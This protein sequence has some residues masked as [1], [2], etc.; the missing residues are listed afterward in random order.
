VFRGDFMANDGTTSAAGG[1]PPRNT[2][3]T[4]LGLVFIAALGVGLFLLR[5]RGSDSQDAADAARNHP[6]V[7]AKLDDFHVAPLTG[8]AKAVT[9]EALRGKVVLVSFWGPWCGYCLEEFP[10]LVKLAEDLRSRDDFAWLPVTYPA[11]LTDSPAKLR[12]DASNYLSKNGF[13]TATYS[14][15]DGS[16]LAHA[17]TVG[18]F[19]GGFPLTIL[20]DRQGRIVAVWSG[21]K[22]GAERQVEAAI[23]EQLE[24][25]AAK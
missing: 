25:S 13:E 10:H 15:T 14:D 5:N 19:E 3:L 18:A 2:S 20:L 6:A 12:E 22:N 21:Y 7:G 4:L 24:S 23:A 8:D 1:E 17:Q 11:S 16:L 9:P